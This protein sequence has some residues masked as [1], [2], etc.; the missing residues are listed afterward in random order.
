MQPPSMRWPPRE[1]SDAPQVGATWG[2][3][4]S[5]PARWPWS[6]LA[7]GV[8]S[9]WTQGAG[10]VKAL[11]PFCR[12]GGHHR[13]F[14]EVHLAKSRR[15]GRL[16][17]RPLPHVITTSYLTHAP[18]AAFLAAE[19]DREGRPYGYPGPLHLSPGRTVGLRMIPMARDLRFAW[20]EMPQQLLDEQAQKV[21]D[22]L[23]HALIGWAQGAGEGSDYTDNVPLQCLHPVGHWYEVPNLLKN[24]VLARLL[25]EQP[26]SA[27]PDGAQR[28]CAGH[29]RG[30][31]D[32]RV[33]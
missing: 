31:G 17:G 23:R 25:A 6:R 16:A 8:G 30:S 11:H 2:W 29:R 9:R 5:P 7:G 12:L 28:R 24:G 27:I 32:A 4:R 3:L 15:I 1:I 10:V 22:S 18:I 14:I 20:E 21:R 26:E 19:A 33:G 13:T